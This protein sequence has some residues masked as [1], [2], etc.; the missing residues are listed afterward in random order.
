MELEKVI[1]K[2]VKELNDLFKELEPR[3]KQ[4]L[5]ELIDNVA[6]TEVRLKQIQE[7][8]LSDTA[9]KTELKEQTQMYNSMSKNYLAAISKL[10]AELP[11]DVAKD[12]LT[13]WLES[14]RK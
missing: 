14:H 13:E 2:R 5:R 6:F 3:K 9:T 12:E 4:I 7:V 11:P 10:L 8:L 1:K